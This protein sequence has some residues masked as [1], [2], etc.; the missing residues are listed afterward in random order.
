MHFHAVDA[1]NFGRNLGQTVDAQ[2]LKSAE[3]EVKRMESSLDRLKE[4]YVEGSISRSEFN[5]QS[6]RYKQQLI[7]ANGRLGS[8]APDL[9]KI[10]Q[11]LARL[12]SIIDV[13]QE[14][15]LEEQREAVDALTE[16]VEER[17]G[18]IVRVVFREWARGLLDE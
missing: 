4:L 7:E 15:S 13:V 11:R 5:R 10:E 16:R 6:E 12:D 8:V 14:G 9:R 17:D 2:S 1:W 18:K 3:Q